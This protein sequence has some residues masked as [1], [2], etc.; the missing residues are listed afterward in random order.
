MRVADEPVGEAGRREVERTGVRHPEMR[1]PGSALVLHGGQRSGPDDGHGAV[2]HAATSGT[3]RTRVPG[4]SSAAGT[5][6]WSHS[7]VSVVPISC[8]PPG[9]ERGYTPV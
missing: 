2:R 3:K 1:V 4:V 9:D 8:Q 6:A 5:R 7:T